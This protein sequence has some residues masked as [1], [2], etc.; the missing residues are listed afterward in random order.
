MAETRF[1]LKR[2][3][4]RKDIDV[5]DNMQVGREV[6]DDQIKLL[7]EGASRHHAS[8]SIVNGTVYLQDE[9]SRNGT[10][11]N[12]QR[13]AAPVALNSGDQLRFYNERFEFRAERSD[14]T[15]PGEP[16]AVHTIPVTEEDRARYARDQAMRALPPPQDVRTPCF[17][18]Y[19]KG[20]E[21][22]R[23]AL[24][25][26]CA[27]PNSTEDGTAGLE[28]Q[29][30]RGATRAIHLDAGDISDEHA[31]IVRQGS[32]WKLDHRCA[33]NGSY[34]NGV[35]VTMR[36]L[37]SGTRLQFSSVDGIF[38]LPGKAGAAQRRAGKSNRTLK[39]VAIA[40]TASF[41]AAL[42]VVAALI[43]FGFI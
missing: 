30:G 2:L 32:R 18:V 16:D 41:A 35:A 26:D 39:I 1:I 40:L 10:F 29:I 25:D 23:F 22:R 27:S 3:S 5:R 11:V 14:A 24:T 6:A 4:T 31:A 15:V 8:L 34:A 43:H 38:Y 20:Q 28:W 9:K 21:V 36:Y 37:E 19:A 17:I 12:D 7:D 42:L 13:L 33:T